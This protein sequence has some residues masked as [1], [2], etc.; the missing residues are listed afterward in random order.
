M[1]PLAKASALLCLAVSNCPGCTSQVLWQNAPPPLHLHLIKWHKYGK[2]RA[3]ACCQLQ[4]ARAP[5]APPAEWRLPAAATAPGT[6]Q[7]CAAA[8]AAPAAG[9][10]PAGAPLRASG[11]APREARQ[12]V[13]RRGRHSAPLRRSQ[14]PAGG[15][16]C[17]EAPR[18]QRPAVGFSQPFQQGVR[19]AQQE[20][21]SRIIAAI[22]QSQLQC[23][24]TIGVVHGGCAGRCSRQRLHWKRLPADCRHMQGR[25]PPAHPG[26]ALWPALPLA[27]A[28][29]CQQPRTLP[30]GGAACRA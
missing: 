13:A 5:L 11:P 21:A 4:R 20:V 9:A 22:A 18:G 3:I 26:P 14:R 7:K 27:A 30:R 15:Q 12:P 16:V 8:G 10:G 29:R 23:C 2:L 28:T 17:V 25:A 19:A 1:S 6:A 24:Q